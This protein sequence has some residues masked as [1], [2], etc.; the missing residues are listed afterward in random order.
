MDVLKQDMKVVGMSEDDVDEGRWFA[1]ATPKGRSLKIAVF[2]D[3][4]KQ[5]AVL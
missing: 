1:V 3:Q 2:A 4:T 5:I